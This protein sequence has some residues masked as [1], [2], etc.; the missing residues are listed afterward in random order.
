MNTHVLLVSAQ[1][2]LHA[3]ASAWPHDTERHSHESDPTVEPQRMPGPQL[4]VHAPPL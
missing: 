1:A 2:P 3:G 4:P